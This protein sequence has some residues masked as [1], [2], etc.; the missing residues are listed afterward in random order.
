MLDVTD[1][2]VNLAR[3]ETEE[4]ARCEAVITQ[5]WDTFVEVGRALATIRDRRLYR[6]THG[7]FEEYCRGKW[8]FSKTHANRQI[9]AARVV[10]ILAPIGVKP[11][12]EA[13]ARALAG[14]EEEHVKRVWMK[15]I[16]AAPNGVV[17]AKLIRREADEFRPVSRKSRG[18]Q[19]SKS[20]GKLSG[21][22]AL[23][24]A[25]R[26]IESVAKSLRREKGA[27]SAVLLLDG[28]KMQLQRALRDLDS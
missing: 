3:T 21:V 20:S 12:N 18:K 7:T 9:E 14:L 17:T 27:D 13:Q 26:L 4:L 15:A 19:N 28:A 24:E 2:P 10:D 1:L 11:E 8:Q 6:D 16:E 5:G 23:G 22:N 25:L